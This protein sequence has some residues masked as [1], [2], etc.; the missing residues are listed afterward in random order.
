MSKQAYILI[1]VICVVLIIYLMRKPLLTMTDSL[2]DDI[3][4]FII[5]F[6][7]GG[8]VSP[9]Q[10]KKIGDTGGETKYGISKANN[11]SVDIKNL[12][13]DQ[14]VSIYKNKY[15]PSVPLITN[16]N[17]FYQVLDMTINAGPSAALKLYKPGITADQYRSARL[18]YYSGLKLWANPD[19]QKSWVNRAN[20][21]FL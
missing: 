2:K 9:E 20:R 14:A 17:L 8:Y 11:P 4:K 7:E 13:L 1:G 6:N 16:P 3:I 15:L 12:T 5:R 10:A 19:V 21:S 18:S